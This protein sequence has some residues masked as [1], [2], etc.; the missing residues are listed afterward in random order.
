MLISATGA[1]RVGLLASVANLTEVAQALEFG[2]DI[3]DL[4][5]PAAGAL[6]AW[7]AVD[8]AK[9]VRLVDGQV[10]VSAT[11]GDLPMDAVRLAAAARAAA[12]TGVDIVKLGFFPA[13]DQHAIALA[14]AP[15]AHA[16]IRLVAVLMADRRPDLALVP[17]LAEAGFYG[18]M[19]DTADKCAGGLRQHLGVAELQGFVTA[20]RGHGLLSGLAGSLRLADVAPLGRLRPDYLGFRGALCGGDR[21]DALDVPAARAVRRA[22]G[23]LFRPWPPSALSA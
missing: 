12:A 11:V 23:A 6:G 22:V 13:P 1:D 3:L 9:A 4:K 15:L 14:L 20:A 19:L 17:T 16:G 18:V 7:P 8:L 21:T 2:A 5:D 10:P